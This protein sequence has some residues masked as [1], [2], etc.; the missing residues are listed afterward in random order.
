MT[1]SRWEL[2]CQGK[3]RKAVTRATVHRDET[4]GHRP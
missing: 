1:T 3:A 2:G 4:V